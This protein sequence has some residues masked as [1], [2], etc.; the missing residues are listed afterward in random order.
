M[1]SST[2][3][4]KELCMGNGPQK[5]GF[6]NSPGIPLVVYSSNVIPKELCMGNMDLKRR[7]F[8]ELPWNSSSGSLFKRRTCSFGGA[9]EYSSTGV[10]K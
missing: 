7:P 4:P 6:W 8:V 9:E 3:I 10:A 5:E 2:G 1:Y